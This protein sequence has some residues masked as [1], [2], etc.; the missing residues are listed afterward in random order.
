MVR[1]PAVAGQ[2]YPANPDRLRQEVRE[3]LVS[4]P[5]PIEA[6]GC[7]VPHAGYMY[8]GSVA[9]AV[10]GALRLPSLF[11]IVCPNHT[12][13]GGPMAIMSSGEWRTPLG[14]ARIDGEL[15]GHLLRACPML[16]EDADAHADE[17]SLEVQ[18]PFLQY[19]VPQMRFVPIAIGRGDLAALDEF[20]QALGQALAGWREPLLI[21][22]SSDM[23]HYERDEVTR[24]KDGRAIEAI[25]ALDPQR[26]YRVLREDHNTMCGYGP[27]ISMLQAAR[28]L[29]ADAA[30]LIRYATSADA[31]GR[32]SAVVG[33]AGIAVHKT[34]TS[35]E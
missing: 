2:F 14:A 10:Y 8:S 34:V 31:G 26:L 1:S 35:D 25:L 6:L 30:T 19:R 21:V 9:G 20:G 24:A 32:R 4:A 12:G 27:V 33:Y 3:F 28:C 13:Q 29:G 23:N 16:R 5:Q 17:H 18:L 22:A 15:G 7:L 11:V